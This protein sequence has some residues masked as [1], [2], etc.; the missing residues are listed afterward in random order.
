MWTFDRHPLYCANQLHPTSGRGP[1]G[2]HQEAGLQKVD[3]PLE[4]IQR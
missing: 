3:L 1:V 4:K 2:L